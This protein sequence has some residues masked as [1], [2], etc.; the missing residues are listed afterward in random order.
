MPSV[1]DA[2]LSATPADAT[3]GRRG[4]RRPARRPGRP[5]TPS[6]EPAPMTDV[7]ISPRASRLAAE[8]GID[9]SHLAGTGPDGRIVERDVQA[10]IASGEA[11]PPTTGA[12]ATAAPAGPVDA[13]EEPPR[14][15]SRMRRVIAERLTASWTTT[16]HFTVTVAVDVT[17]APGAPRRGS[18]PPGT[19]LT[20]TDFV[21]AATADTLAEF[22]DVNARTDGI[23]VWPRSRVHLGM[24]VPVP[25]GLVVPVIRD[26]DR[27]TV[28]EIHDRA[29][30]LATAARDGT[31]SVDDLT[32]Q[33]L[34]G[35]Q[36]GHARR[37]GVQRDHQ[38]GRGRDPRRLG[39]DPDARWRWA[40]RSR[41]ARS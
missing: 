28:D 8:A 35:V 16:P 22:P 31:A 13:G 17:E 29:A 20:V 6:A 18:R 1:P 40:R 9:P 30:A 5:A 14:P 2:V 10:A 12:A 32:G 39:R 4:R 38:P 25:A 21:L 37:R 3:A 23:S 26:A 27:L 33:H 36:P 7:R 19:N 24:A 11:A 34:H 15:M 41:S